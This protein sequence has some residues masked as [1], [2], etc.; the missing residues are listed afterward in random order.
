MDSK[1][2]YSEAPD[3]SWHKLH[4]TLISPFVLEGIVAMYRE[5]GFDIYAYNTQRRR[6]IKKYDELRIWIYYKKIKQSK[7]RV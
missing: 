6:I 2:L 4:E 3:E 1:F 7:V 5:Y